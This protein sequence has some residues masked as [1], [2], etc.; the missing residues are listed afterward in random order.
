MMHQQ[1]L[2]NENNSI[3]FN[4]LVEVIHSATPVIG[5]PLTGPIG[6]R[7]FI[8]VKAKKQNIL[9]EF[10]AETVLKDQPENFKLGYVEGDVASYKGVT[11]LHFGNQMSINR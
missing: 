4:K 7:C 9:F 11:V 8:P 5:H 10:F 3:D 1:I 6:K 2:C